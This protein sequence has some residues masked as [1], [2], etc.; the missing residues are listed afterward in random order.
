MINLFG[1]GSTSAGSCVVSTVNNGPNIDCLE[2]PDLPFTPL[3]DSTSFV[4]RR[5]EI[6]WQHNFPQTRVPTFDEEGT[7]GFTSLGAPDASVEGLP[8]GGNSVTGGI[9]VTELMTLLP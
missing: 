1:Y 7:A 3:D 5:P 2:T 9:S 8:F 4:H 6:E